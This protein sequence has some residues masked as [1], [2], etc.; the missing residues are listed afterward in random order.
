MNSFFRYLRVSFK[1]ALKIYPSIILFTIVLAIGLGALAGGLFAEKMQEKMRFKIGLVGDLE[2]SYLEIG[3]YAVENFDSSKYYVEFEKLSREEA[4]QKLE[5]GDIT[6]YLDIPDGFIRSV[7]RG[8]NLKIKYVTGNSPS[9]LSA[10]IVD[11]ILMSISDIV[12]ETQNGCFALI[13]IAGENGVSLSISDDLTFEYLDIVL[14]REE[15]YD[16]EYLGFSAGQSFE[17]YYTCVILIVMLLLWGILCVNMLVKTDLSTERLLYVQG[18]GVKKQ[19]IAEFLPYLAVAMINLSLLTTALNFVGFE[20]LSH[21]RGVGDFILLAFKLLPAVFMLCT[22]QFLFYEL[23]SNVISAVLLQIF[24]AVALSYVSGFFYP[25]DAL[26]ALLRNISA[27]L[28]TGIALQYVINAF[29]DL[30][31]TADAFICVVYGA[32]LLLL[33]CVVRKIKFRRGRI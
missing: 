16:I 24:S 14:D 3:I 11:E 6:A 17:A 1:R 26:P 32:L 25:S 20:F 4:I 15:I 21:M 33:A 5:A 29:N 2:G 19:I 10:L 30:P 7:S 23:T 9:M 22:M 28:P 13:E 31:L 8:K 12:V 18:L 27:L